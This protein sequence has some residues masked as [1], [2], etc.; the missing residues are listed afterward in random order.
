MMVFWVV[1]NY[2][3][4]YDM[5]VCNGILFNYESFRRGEIFVTRKII[6]VVVNIKVGK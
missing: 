6:F 5:Y 1:V 2:C 3:E 4:L